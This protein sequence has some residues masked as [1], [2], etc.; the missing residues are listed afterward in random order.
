MTKDYDRQNAQI[1]RTTNRRRTMQHAEE[2][3]QE[4]RN[5]AYNKETAVYIAA[6]KG[7]DPEAL[8]HLVNR[9]LWSDVAEATGL[10]I[11]EIKAHMAPATAPEHTEHMDVIRHLAAGNA[12]DLAA[13]IAEGQI[14]EWTDPDQ[15][16]NYTGYNAV[17]YLP[18][19]NR[20]VWITNGDPTWFDATSLED[21]VRQVKTESD[22]IN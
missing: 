3:T 8:R 7:L 19:C 13:L 4:A 22:L 16:P 21:A 9:M 11:A 20:A 12:D 6:A 18:S 14:E 2:T 15:Y 1:T 17:G 5:R 10:T